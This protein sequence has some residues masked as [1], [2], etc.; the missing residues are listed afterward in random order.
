MNIK[1]NNIYLIVWKRV[2]HLIYP[3]DFFKG[4]VNAVRHVGDEWYAQLYVLNYP[5]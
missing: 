4:K 1:I 3:L 2:C 5:R